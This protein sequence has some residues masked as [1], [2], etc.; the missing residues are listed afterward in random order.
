[1]IKPPARIQVELPEVRVRQPRRAAAIRLLRPHGFGTAKK[2]ARMIVVRRERELLQHGLGVLIRA[3]DEGHGRGHVHEAPAQFRVADRV[4]RAERPVAPDELVERDGERAFPEIQRLPRAGRR[5]RHREKG[6]R[7]DAHRPH[8]VGREQ[9]HLDG[10]V[11]SRALELVIQRERPGFK[12]CSRHETGHGFGC[13][14]AEGL[15]EPGHL[16]R[17]DAHAVVEKYATQRPRPRAAQ[18]RLRL[19]RPD[20]AELGRDLRARRERGVNGRDVHVARVFEPVV[21]DAADEQQ[22]VENLP[23]VVGINTGALQARADVLR[24]DERGEVEGVVHLRG[25]VHVAVLVAR[26]GDERVIPPGLDLLQLRSI[27][28]E[29]APVGHAEILRGER[30]W[31]AAERA[32]A[33][34]IN[35]RVR[36][37]ER[38][39]VVQPREQQQR[40]RAGIPLV[41]PADVEIGPLLFR[42]A[43]RGA[44]AGL[45][46][47]FLHVAGLG[48]VILRL[49]KHAVLR[50]QLLLE[51]H[52][53]VELTHVV[54]R[55]RA[56]VGMML[57][58]HGETA[59]AG[60][61]EHRALL[62]PR[63]TAAI[64]GDGTHAQPVALKQLGI[65]LLR[66]VRREIP[67]ADRRQQVRQQQFAQPRRLVAQVDL[68]RVAQ[69]VVAAG[70]KLVRRK[71]SVVC[72]HGA[73]GFAHAQIGHARVAIHTGKVRA[74]DGAVLIQQQAR[75]EN[76]PVVVQVLRFFEIGDGV[77]DFVFLLREE[78]GVEPRRGVVRV[79]LLCE[80]QFFFRAL[81]SKL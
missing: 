45:I 62:V 26:T 79:E 22:W 8:R 20:E 77:V 54:V 24:A 43:Q 11:G 7:H 12:T 38:E 27:G 15:V 10:D 61:A 55:A 47:I 67:R 81:E 40:V 42:D 31:I 52:G 28:R 73:S 9:V 4:A 34:E 74:A 39:R 51:F 76:F 14:T 49:E 72:A 70:E 16:H 69:G 35:L 13:E 32:V 66:N 21:G 17:L 44:G 6:V 18:M 3:A 71:I 56:G 60:R 36:I 46:V 50:G 57:H 19:W 58:I 41:M 1:M 64:L 78:R 5:I 37:G 2:S 63:A 65:F 59:V 29:V 53:E 68:L 48:V 25:H 30:D 75:A 80:L 23:L 33:V